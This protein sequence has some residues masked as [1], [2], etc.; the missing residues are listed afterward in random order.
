MTVQEKPCGLC[1]GMPVWGRSQ[2]SQLHAGIYEKNR[3]VWLFTVLCKKEQIPA[4]EQIIF[5]ETTTIGIRRQDG[6][7][8][9]ETGKKNGYNPS[10]GGRSK[11]SALLMERNIFTRNMKV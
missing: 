1:Y 11:K 8:H 6:E 7:N 5:R 2:R 9:S 4:M 10:G 3:P